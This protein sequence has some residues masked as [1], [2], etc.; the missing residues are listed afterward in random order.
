MVKPF[1]MPFLTT[2][3]IAYIFYPVFS[4]ISQ[5]VKS[6]GW[7]SV[8]MVLIV[9]LIVIIPSIY[10]VSELI[11][12][13]PGAYSKVSDVIQNT[14]FIQNNL[15]ESYLSDLG[16]N[17][18]IKDLLETFVGVVLTKLQ[19]ILTSIPSKILYTSIGA[20]FLFFIFKDGDRLVKKLVSYLPFGRKKSLII[21]RHLKNMAD[22]VIYGQIVTAFIQAVLA[23]G[24]YV[25]LGLKAPLLLGV[26][27][28]V[29]ALIPMIGPMFMYL[30]LSLSMITSSI[31]GNQSSSLF[32][33]IALLIYGLAII[34]SVDNIVKPLLISEKVR[35]HPALVVVGVIGGLTVF[36][37]LGVVLGPLILALLSSLF[38]IYEMKDEM[39]EQRVTVKKKKK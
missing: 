29:F 17:I 18:D 3:L 37:V 11:S 10:V 26:I 23:T 13:I 15:Y 24:A 16:I 34:S 2:V 22:A 35:L 36:G 7:S 19:S 14:T 20:F 38:K 6:R 39:I 1:I 12:E 30:P 32:K 4:K 28:F 33:G 31:I 5:K 9:F 8:I 27:T 25:V 21:L